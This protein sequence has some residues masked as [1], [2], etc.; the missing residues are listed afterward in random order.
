MQCVPRSSTRCKITLLHTHLKVSARRSRDVMGSLHKCCL[1]KLVSTKPWSL[2]KFCGIM[3][4]YLVK[5]S[6][7]PESSSFFI[8]SN[9]FTS[10]EIQEKDDVNKVPNECNVP[11]C[12]TRF[13]PF[14]CATP[15]EPTISSVS[16]SSA[17]F[18]QQQHFLF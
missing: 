12:K 5:Y 16:S 13:P 3:R 9:D 4:K 6:V 17:A 18:F 2:S 15:G 7:S 1:V 8:C 10:Q 11:Q 14:D